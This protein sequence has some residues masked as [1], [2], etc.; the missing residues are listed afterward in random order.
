MKHTEQSLLREI[1]QIKRQ[2]KFINLQKEALSSALLSEGLTDSLVD[3]IFGPFLHLS[4][5]KLRNTKEW[6]DTQAKIKELTKKAEMLGAKADK[7]H[8]EYEK[9]LADKFAK[10]H[11]NTKALKATKPL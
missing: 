9:M 3:L 10:Q 1:S 8:A 4:A 6:R 7:A 2:I 11:P 5:L